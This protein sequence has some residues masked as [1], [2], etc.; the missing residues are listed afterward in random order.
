MEILNVRNCFKLIVW[1]NGYVVL[2]YQRCFLIPEH[3]EFIL[4]FIYFPDRQAQ[5]RMSTKEVYEG[6]GRGREIAMDP[7]IFQQRQLEVYGGGLCPAEDILW[8]I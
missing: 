4:C 2:I 3:T 1:F 8:Q 5:R 6:P 7:D